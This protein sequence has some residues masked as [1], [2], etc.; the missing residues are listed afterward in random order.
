[1]EQMMI[2]TK[3]RPYPV[4]LG[5]GIID[6]VG[7]WLLSVCN[8]PSKILIITDQ[9]IKDLY[10]GKLESVLK[11]FDLDVLTCVVPS[12][13]QSKSFET[14]YKCLTF[15]LENNLDRES[16]IIAFGGG[17]VGDLAGFVAATFMR[18]IPFIQVPTT[19]LAHDSAVGGKVAIN[20][21]LGKNMIGAFHQPHAIIYDTQFLKTLPLLE[22]R[23]GFAEVVKHGFINDRSFVE[24]LMKT[25]HSLNHVTSEQ[26]Q[27]F[28]RKGIE[29]KAEIVAED[30]R[31]TGK[32]AFLNFGHTL[33]HA[34]EAELGYGK[35]SHGDA[36]ACGMLFALWLSEKIF[37]KDFQYKSTKN[38]FN[39]IGFPVKIDENIQTESLLERM[40]K[41]KKTVHSQ[42]RFVLLEDIGNPVLKTFD[43]HTLYSFLNEWR[44]EGCV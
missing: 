34:L 35:I 18:G 15:A 2:Q 32:R 28:I 6:N 42:I 1:M 3:S 22:I 44:T 41:D 23:S 19:L 17:V 8:N 29:V 36:V 40:K 31:E 13:E 38:W 16:V 25:I 9:T 20:H 11:A 5:D 33:G 39:E 21:P 26:L 37:R 30:E 7:E 14:Y 12:G 24:N 4:F 10:G 27:W 43:T